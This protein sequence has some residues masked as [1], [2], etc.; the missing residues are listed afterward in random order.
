MK[1]VITGGD[2]F[3]GSHNAEFVLEK[4]EDSEVILV[5][6]LSRAHGENYGY[7]KDKFGDRV[8]LLEEDVRHL[9][10]IKDAFVDADRVYHMA[11]Q[12]TMTKSID[13]PVY[14]YEVNSTGTFNVLESMRLKCPD[15]PIVYCSTNKVYGDLLR[16]VRG[17]DGA[18]RLEKLDGDT[19]IEV[20]DNR[21]TYRDPDITGVI[22]EGFHVGPEAANCPY[23]ASKMAGELWMKNFHDT[24]GM[25]TVR[26][27][28]SCIYGTR[29]Y[30]NEDQGWLS[31]FAIRAILGKNIVIYGDGMQVRDVLFCIDHARAFDLLATT[32]ACYGEA[33]NLGG[34]PDNTLTL[35][36]LI[37]L[38]DEFTGKRSP[39][40]YDAWRH[41]DQ[42]VYISNI[43]KIKAV[44]GFVPE[45]K[46]REGVR[47]LLEWTG[48]NID[49]IVDVSKEQ[50]TRDL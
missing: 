22:E 27:R 30:G 7:L 3:V 47:Q 4:Y 28:M 1:I 23:G 13:D 46:P 38:I 25:K 49:K 12:V 29:Q 26:A 5:D 19:D 45:V 24:Y 48:D 35:L 6:N 21:Y 14:D 34:G 17:N 43:D 50:V 37:E 16:V 40:K 36:D 18:I 41:G 39:V 15:A 31:W 32:P 44:T 33:F 11:A 42:K 2:G 9:D 20:K 8:T 10:T